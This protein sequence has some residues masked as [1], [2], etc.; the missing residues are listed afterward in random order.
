MSQR[1]ACKRPLGLDKQEKVC[2]S[3]EKRGHSESGVLLLVLFILLGA[4]SVRPIWGF[5]F[6]A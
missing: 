3:A 1:G 6:I 5:L 4:A 2:V